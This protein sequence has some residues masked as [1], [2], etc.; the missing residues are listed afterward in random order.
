MVQAVFIDRD[1]TLGGTGHFIHPRDFTLFEGVQHSLTALKQ[2]GIRMFAFTNQ[3]R[4]SRGEATVEDFRLQFAQYG[5]DD[6][7][8]CPHAGSEACHCRKP[9]P[10]MLHE[11]AR[12]YKLDLTKCAVIG[13]VG[14][15]DMLAAHAAGALKILVRTGWGEGSLHD[16]RHTWKD[17]HP[18]YVA[19]DINEAVKWILESNL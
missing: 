5:F 10:G 11:A 16:F 1:G 7:L 12:T 2:S 13:D 6:S 15:T 8:I 17:V 3:T 19:A 4:I 18:D 9:K 14:A